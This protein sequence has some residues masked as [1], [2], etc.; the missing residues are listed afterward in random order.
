M[1]MV[2]LQR[3][4]KKNQ[5]MFRLLV[6]DKQNGP[7]SGRF[8]EILGSYNP[9]TNE[10]NFKKDRIKHWLDNGAQPSD[11]VHNLLVSEKI[12]EGK[13]KNVLSKKTPIKKEEEEK[14]AEEAPAAE[15]EAPKE[16]AP[17]EETKEEEKREGAP[18]EEEK[19]AE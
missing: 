9:H 2:R 4:G 7:K 18:K 3:V 8:L 1:L 12:I 19:P 5:A 13:K 10:K 11:T 16:E 6:T 14:P 17:A 15:E